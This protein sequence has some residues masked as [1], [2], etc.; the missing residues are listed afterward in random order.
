MAKM[1]MKKVDFKQ[2]LVEKGERIGLGA[3]GVVC[4]L[5][6]LPMFWF[7][8]FG[9][10]SKNIVD[11]LTKPATALKTK[12]ATSVPSDADNPPKTST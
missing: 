6:I 12:Q 11:E 9:D 2:L 8:F 10:S 3:A 1:K 4:G 5:M 7:L